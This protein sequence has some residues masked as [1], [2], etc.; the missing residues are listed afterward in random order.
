MHIYI[1][2]DFVQNIKF[3]LFYT[4]TTKYSGGHGDEGEKNK[5]CFYERWS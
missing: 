1:N 4:K 5:D 3:I 2:I